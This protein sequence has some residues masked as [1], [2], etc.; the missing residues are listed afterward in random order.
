[1][2][3]NVNL[4]ARPTSSSGPTQE[5]VLS[6][7]HWTDFL[8]SF[9]ITR[10]AGFRFRSGEFV[11]IGLEVEGKPLLRAYSIASPSWGDEL[12]F[13]SIKVPDGPLTSRLQ[14]IEAGDTVLLGRKPVGT[15][16]VDALTPGENL[17]LLSTGTGFA[18]FASVIRD[19]ETYEKFKRVIVTHTT[20]E[21]AE[22]DYSKATLGALM[23]HEF[24]GEL[25]AGKLYY[26]DSVTREPYFRNG[27]ITTFIESGELFL[28]TD[29]PPFDLVRDRAMICGS[30]G[31]I[32]DTKTLLEK[33]GLTEGSNASPAEFVVEKAFVG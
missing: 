7:T 17:Y 27:R 8:F 16:V 21:A 24:L 3:L 10:P 25:A 4:Q 11:M 13:F 1:M 19:P 18:P 28:A 26:F 29:L 9:R 31:M 5:K 20:R 14:Q 2:N 22:L 32:Q 30:M 23:E 33:A 12:E 6:V 15:L